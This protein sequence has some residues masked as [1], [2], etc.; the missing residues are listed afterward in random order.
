VAGCCKDGDEPSGSGA[1]DLVTG[2]QMGEGSEDHQLQ[3]GFFVHNRII[4]A[5]RRVEFVM[6]MISYIILK[7]PGAKLFF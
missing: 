3:T 2:G 6:N 5:V 7:R 4:S 1:T